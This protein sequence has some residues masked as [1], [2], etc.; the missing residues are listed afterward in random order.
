[1]NREDEFLKGIGRI[2]LLASLALA[3]T[4]VLAALLTLF[5]N[6]VIR[7]GESEADQLPVVQR[8]K[9]NIWHARDIS[10]ISNASQRAQVQYGRDLI[11]HTA[12]FL[13]PSGSGSHI[14]NGMNC[15]NCH[16]DAGTRPFGNNY[17]AVAATYPKFRARSGSVESLEKR[18]NDCFERSLNGEPLD[19]TS[20]EM[21]AIISYLHFI[22]S[23]VAANEI[24][25]GVGLK[26]IA[27]LDRGADPGKARLL[28]EEKCQACHGSQGE[29]VM[30][31]DGGEYQFPPLWGDHSYN[32]GAGLFRLTNF[33]QFI[34][35]NMPLGAT[36][37]NPILTEEEAWDIAA[38]VN[39]LPRPVKDL[40]RDWPNIESKPFDHPFGPFADSFPEHQHKYGPFKEIHQ[41]YLKRDK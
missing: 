36:F 23:N 1:M 18:V 31:H 2:R 16:L 37:D 27:F 10:A 11:A 5:L 25:D 40:S 19:T 35:S 21:T 9:N 26:K 3:S 29:G 4:I 33:A 17:A 8:K 38:Y 13:G 28:Y 30:G 41:F 14:S 7:K 12:R 39:S 6:G 15:Q 20:Y 32:T 34:H 24:P 22:G